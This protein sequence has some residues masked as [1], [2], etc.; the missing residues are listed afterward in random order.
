MP[1]RRASAIF[2][3]NYFLLYVTY[4]VLTPYLPLYLKARG[5]TPSRIGVLLGVVEIAGFAGP[6]LVSRLADRL[7][8]E[9]GFGAA[10]RALLAASIAVAA[11][12][13]VPLELT[14]RFGIAAVLMALLGFTFR[15]TS[16][17]LDSAVGR[18]LPDPARQYGTFRAA[19]SIGFIIM[20]LLLQFGGLISSESS[21]SILLAFVVTVLPA[22]AAALFLPAVPRARGPRSSMSLR[23]A[24]VFDRSFWAVI[25][26]V[27]LGR[28]AMGAYYS[29]FS[30]YLQDSFRG[31]AAG[32]AGSG[33]SLMW[34]L[35]AVAEIAPLWLSGRLIARWGLRLVLLV[36]LAAISLRLSLFVLAPTL[37][38][39]AL[40][41]LLH[42]FTFGTFHPAAVA[43]VNTK[44][45]AEH[46]GLGMAIYTAVGI[47]L[48]SFSASVAGGYVV[49]AFG[50]RALFVSYAVIPLAAIAV[51]FTKAGRIG[52]LD[53]WKPRPF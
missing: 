39:I 32:F 10:Y 35:G 3:S 15:S 20:S 37:G 7:T 34:A 44:I 17:L 14:S 13:L 29:F 21:R 47:G 53:P 28:F 1:G 26:I 43:Y 8:A 41:Q 42:A 36:S 30:L 16:P 12:A 49:E 52:I 4:G 33:V 27:F 22:F 40:A 25:G 46:R 48:A 38:L 31:T 24:R 23:R 11:I 5:F 45:P 2:V 9:R 6:L 18:L 50:Y 51:L 19:G